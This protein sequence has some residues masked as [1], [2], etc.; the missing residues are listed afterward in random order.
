MIIHLF[1]FNYTVNFI[2]KGIIHNYKFKRG[3]SI[4][5]NEKILIKVDTQDKIFKYK[6]YIAKSFNKI[7]YH[8]IKIN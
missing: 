8:L 3:N 1:K 4:D 2:F 7:I 5:I 6:N